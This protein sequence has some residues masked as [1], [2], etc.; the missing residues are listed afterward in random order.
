MATAKKI[1][2]EIQAA[3]TGRGAVKQ[4]SDDLKSLKQVESFQAML[5]KFKGLNDQFVDAKAKMRS[6]RAEMAKP[7]NEAM[8]SEYERSVTAVN[9]LGAAIRKQKTTIDDQHNTMRTAGFDLKNLTVEYDRLKQSITGLG[10]LQAMRNLLG[11]ET[12]SEV[13]EKMA[14]LVKIY[15]EAKEAGFASSVDQQRALAALRAETKK[16]YATIANPPQLQKARNILGIQSPSEI[17]KEMAVLTKAYRDI[18][19]AANTSAADQAKALDNLRKKQRE[20]YATISN[21]P[22]LQNA[23][24][25]LGL[26]DQAAINA[27]VAE[28][29]RAYDTLASSGTLSTQQLVQAKKNLSNRID[30]INGKV[31]TSN[32]LFTK[33]GG[34]AAG[35]F[36]VGVAVNYANQVRQIAD[37]YTNINSRLKLVTGSSAELKFV[38]EE[39]YKISQKTGTNYAD[40]ADSY[41]KLA[42]S[43]KQ[44]GADS[45]EVLLI[46]ELVN[47][48]LTINGSTTAMT[49][50]FMLQ[51]AQAMGSGILQG[52]EFRAM[53]ESNSYFAGLL[54][55]ALGTNI[56]GLRQMSKD[57]QLTADKLRSAFPQMAEKINASFEKIAPTTSRAM[58]AL[59]N[60]FKRII[61]ESNTASNG[62]GT[63]SKEI[64]NLA[65]TIDKN[66]EGIISLFSKIISLAADTAEALGNIGQSLAGWDAVN[67][68]KL[69]MLEFA[70]MD[71]KELNAWLKSNTKEL[72]D[73]KKI[74]KDEGQK[75]QSEKQPEPGKIDGFSKL[76][77]EMMDKSDD[78]YLSPEKKAALKKYREQKKPKEEPP[79]AEPDQEKKIDG[80]SLDELKNMEGWDEAKLTDRQKEAV[81]KYRKRKPDEKPVPPPSEKTPPKQDPPSEKKPEPETVDG[82]SLLELEAMDTWDED[83]LTPERKSAVEKYREKKKKAEEAS[84]P[85]DKEEA[86][87]KADEEQDAEE[88]KQQEETAERE[89]KGEEA[90][91]EPSL[92]AKERSGELAREKEE[93][94]AR[95][96]EEEEARK[97]S[98]GEQ[99]KQ[100]K[101]DKEPEVTGS[102]T[103]SIIT[104]EQWQKSLDNAKK[105]EE[106]MQKAHEAV[107]ESAKESAEKW[108][109]A[110]NDA[111]E[112]AKSAFQKYADKVK[113]LQD[114]ISGREKSLAQELDELDTKTPPETKWRRKAKQAKDYEKAAKEALS[115]GNIDQALQ[116]SDQAKEL[117]GSLKDGAGTIPEQ[118]A[119]RLALRG[120]KSTGE[121][122]I[123]LV[124]QQKRAAAAEAMFSLPPGTTEMFGDLTGSIRGKMAGVA[125][126]QGQGKEQVTKVHELKFQG[127]AVRGGEADVEALIN[128]LAQAGM[129]AG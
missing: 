18:A 107:A 105:Y 38:Q 49:S 29:K 99:K 23:R 59:E 77:L 100:K 115:G 21:T 79:A 122:G 84:N 62:T 67:D 46:N 124:S 30:E 37:Q 108:S 125:A 83:K 58:T 22:K 6:L 51:F 25:I 90:Y 44:V 82:F 40:N 65:E 95:E 123:D 32:L 60:A 117:Y 19:T 98:E 33:F 15:R 47:K 76:Q 126:D 2:Y 55:E 72:E 56:A 101:E 75:A 27:K 3:Y 42:F 26:P 129:S 92:L 8:A 28:A 57:G 86:E 80:Y 1:I 9:K 88:E 68:G 78:T 96:R 41:A 102:S 73:Q 5:D 69:S 70:T 104:D 112:K 113:S 52:D 12:V 91:S 14:G 94:N 13:K 63:I 89:K 45:K 11:V 24:N 36:T 128:L 31:K 10:K 39:L 61:D 48:S 87:K 110:Q 85:A 81:E 20:L 17:R 35:A 64:L 7:G 119:R 118:Q 127:G 111:T 43:L 4:L 74:S 53:M 103:S 66:R 50:S 16:L 116:L 71:A 93:R 109:A 120:I 121:M 97:E 34:I 54:A 114:D 106:D